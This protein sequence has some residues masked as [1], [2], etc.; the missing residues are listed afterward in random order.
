[1]HFMFSSCSPTTVHAHMILIIFMHLTIKRLVMHVDEI[2]WLFI[3]CMHL[4]FLI[5][6]L[7]YYGLFCT[8]RLVHIY[9]SRCCLLLLKF[10]YFIIKFKLLFSPSH[11]INQLLTCLSK[12]CVSS[13]ACTPSQI[14][15]CRHN[16]IVQ[17]YKTFILIVDI[18]PFTSLY[19]PHKIKAALYAFFLLFQPYT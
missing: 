10:T 6:L 16:E 14:L 13:F 17:I 2:S 4:F 12:Y 5:S 18:D 15:T 3:T 11:S 19:E 8:F 9:S 1:M 7:L